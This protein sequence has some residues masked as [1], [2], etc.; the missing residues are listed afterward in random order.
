MAETGTDKQT[1][2]SAP[3]IH[4]PEL[5]GGCLMCWVY[6]PEDAI[7]VERGRIVGVDP[8]ACARCGQCVLVCQ[9]TRHARHWP[10]S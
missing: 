1:E 4:D 2:R 6:C 9:P 10:D 7:V 3:P 8:Q 5:C